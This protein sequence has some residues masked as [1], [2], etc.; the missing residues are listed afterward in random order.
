MVAAALCVSGC[1]RAA[2]ITRD[3]LLERARHW[4]EPKVAIWYYIGSKREHDYF[5]FYDLGVSQLYRVPSGVITLSGTFP[6]T[7]D[8][9]KW[10]VMPW[11]PAAKRAQSSNQ[12]MERT[13]TRHAFTLSSAITRSLRATLALG[14][15]RSSC[16][17]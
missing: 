2:D 10:I 8:R 16:S 5:R 14:G 1:E 3:D 4:K 12:A 13:T 7:G 17:R 9:T 6:Y 15:R 11:G